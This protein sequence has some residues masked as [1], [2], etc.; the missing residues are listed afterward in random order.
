MLAHETAH[1]AKGPHLYFIPDETMISKEG[2]KE[3]VRVHTEVDLNG[4]G[5]AV[6][7]EAIV[8]EE[9]LNAGGPDVGIT[10]DVDG[11]YSKL[12]DDYKKGL[13]TWHG[14]VHSMGQ[15]YANEQPS[16]S[17]KGTI[18]RDYYAKSWEGVWDEEMSIRLEHQE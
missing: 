13:D 10:G 5:D 3:F 18:Y 4:E 17:P 8:R 15:L 14:T 9:I 11:K 6:M 7:H 12:Y 16:V 1:A 2:K